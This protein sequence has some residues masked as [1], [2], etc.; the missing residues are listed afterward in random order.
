MMT[1]SADDVM[2]VNGGAISP[3]DGM[4][5]ELAVAT[6]ALAVGAAPLAL[7]AVGAAAVAAWLKD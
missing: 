4:K 3:D 1:L 6:V 2:Q 5:L 7:A